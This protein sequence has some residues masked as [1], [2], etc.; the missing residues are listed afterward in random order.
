[1]IRTFPTNSGGRG[2]IQKLPQ[3]QQNNIAHRQPGPQGLYDPRFEHD[4]CGT[5]FVAHIKG[6]KSHEIVR[7]A[8]TALENMSHRGAAGSEPN[9]GDGAG[10]LFQVPHQFLSLVCHELNIHLPEPGQ[11]GVGMVFLP[12]DAEQRQICEQQF[13]D[14][15]TAEGQDSS[16]LADGANG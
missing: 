9:T 12:P 4:A 1:M 13:A 5:G 11:Y 3:R 2:W 8:L 6:Q 15:V 16:W 14:I 10:I 7:Q